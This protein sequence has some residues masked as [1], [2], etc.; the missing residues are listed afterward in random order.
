MDLSYILNSPDV[1]RIAAALETIADKT[2]ESI[3]GKIDKQQGTGNA[4]KAL[5]VGSDGNVALGTVG[6][7]NAVKTALLACFAKV[8]WVDANGQAYYNALQQALNSGDTPIPIGSAREW[9]YHFN[10]SLQSSG[11]MDFGLTSTSAPVYDTGKFGNGVKFTPSTASSVLRAVNIDSDSVPQLDGDFTVALWFKLIASSPTSG[12]TVVMYRNALRGSA[13]TMAVV[14]PDHLYNGFIQTE[15]ASTSRR[16]MGFGLACVYSSD[17]NGYRLYLTFLK[18]DSSAVLFVRPEYAVTQ[19][20]W[21]HIAVCRTGG[22]ITVYLNGQKVCDFNHAGKL[23]TPDF[24]T[25]GGRQT[26][27]DDYTN[28]TVESGGDVVVDELYINDRKCLYTDEFTVPDTPYHTD[29]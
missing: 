11:S 1:E 20:V 28:M 18:D 17:L 13:D 21:H 16:V 6:I 22:V 7:S 9:I 27:E 12:S 5:V 2:V 25:I 8:A 23:L 3:D 19:N 29:M 15:V 26:D 10:D 24:L 14:N 4:G